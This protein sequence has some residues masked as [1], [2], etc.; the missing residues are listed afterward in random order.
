MVENGKGKKALGKGK[1][2][3]KEDATGEKAL[4]ER[5][6]Y[7]KERRV[8]KQTTQ[9][10]NTSLEGVSRWGA[11]KVGENQQNLKISFFAQ[12]PCASR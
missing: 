11:I 6:A 7:G 2:Y 1:A 4:R 5:S 10:S 8:G 12:I 9:E 3:G